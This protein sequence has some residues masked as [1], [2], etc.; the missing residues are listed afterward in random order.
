ML[1]QNRFLLNLYISKLSERIGI[2]RNSLV[3]FIRYL[4]D[5]RVIRCL[6]SDTKGIGALQKPEKIYLRHPNLQYAL[7]SDN[8][9]I[10]NVRESFFI[11]QLGTL[12]PIKDTP[13]VDFS[14]NDY[15]FE[16]GAR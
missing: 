5:I 8:S 1:F 2:S 7:A 15:A 9:N 12:G 16:V 11:N 6:Y 3:Q 4:E 14:F 13:E 10:G